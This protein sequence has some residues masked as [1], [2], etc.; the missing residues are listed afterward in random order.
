VS[1]GYRLAPEHP[2]PAGPDDAWSV[3]QLLARESVGG[4]RL[5]LAGSSA[6]ANLAL[7][8]ALRAGDADG[9]KPSFQIL[10]HPPLDARCDTPSFQTLA[11]AW[12]LSADLMRWFW[13]GYLVD[14]AL[15]SSPEASPG[16]AKRLD[17]LPPTLLV[18]AGLDVLIEEIEGF[19]ARLHA[20]G[21][22]CVP[23]R[24]SSRLQHL[25]HPAASRLPG[26][27]EAA[28]SGCAPSVESGGGM[29][30]RGRLLSP[31]PQLSCQH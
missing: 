6:G 8:V 1:V 19:E 3:F 29:K 15:Y 24:P 23:E 14:P 16:R 26:D 27:D 7:C 10:V 30:G 31:S 5:G 13:R 4:R 12:P 9:P 17:M 22:Q 20:A 2:F 25:L 28:P 18:S 21:V 11:Q